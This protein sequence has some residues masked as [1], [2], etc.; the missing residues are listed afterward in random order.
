MWGTPN[1]SGTT[2]GA[3]HRDVRNAG[4]VENIDPPTYNAF[5][6]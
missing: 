3:S 5:W 6:F 1:V 2:I 4:L